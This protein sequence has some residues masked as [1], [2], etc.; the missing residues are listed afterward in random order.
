M[1]ES[2]KRRRIRVFD[3]SDFLKI[4]WENYEGLSDGV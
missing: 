1:K 2:F 3:Y 4:G